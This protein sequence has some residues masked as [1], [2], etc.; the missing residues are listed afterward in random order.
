M[1]AIDVLFNVLAEGP[2][3]LGNRI[4]R[5]D[6]RIQPAMCSDRADDLIHHGIT[7]LLLPGEMMKE[8]SLG[9][10]SCFD[11][12]IQ[13]ATLKAILVELRERRQENLLPGGFRR[14]G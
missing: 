14:F 2:L 7:Q 12:M 6:H 8:R 11:N 10:A 9:G 13:T 4:R 1:P 3:E 5:I